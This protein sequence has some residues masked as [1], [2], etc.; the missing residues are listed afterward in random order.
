MPRPV[1]IEGCI[2]LLLPLV[3]AAEEQRAEVE[4]PS[5]VVDLLEPDVF[6]D[7][8]MADVQPTTL[9]ADASVSADP[10][11]FLFGRDIRFLAV[12]T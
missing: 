2:E 4:I 12:S 11:D 3:E 7:E 8:R 6:I 1:C 10:P 5:P 9:P